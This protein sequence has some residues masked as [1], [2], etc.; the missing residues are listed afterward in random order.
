MSGRV[1]KIEKRKRATLSIFL[2]SRRGRGSPVWKRFKKR[3]IQGREQRTQ[4]SPRSWILLNGLIIQEVT[5]ACQRKT[6]HNSS[7]CNTGATRVLETWRAVSCE[8]KPVRAR[9]LHMVSVTVEAK[10]WIHTAGR[11]LRA[12]I[13]WKSASAEASTQ[14]CVSISCQKNVGFTLLQSSRLTR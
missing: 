9:L 7:A 2:S 14:S 10:F 1:K 12:P 5:G 3:L 8:P 6:L 4:K 13:I 11:L